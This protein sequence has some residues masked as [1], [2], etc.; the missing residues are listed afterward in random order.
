MPLFQ[1]IIVTD[2]FNNLTTNSGPVD[3]NTEIMVRQ[4]DGLMLSIGTYAEAKARS[5]PG[6]NRVTRRNG[7]LLGFFGTPQIDNWLISYIPNPSY[8]PPAGPYE[9]P[10]GGKFRSKRSRST[11]RSRSKKSRSKKS[12]RSRRH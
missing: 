1:S 6:S 11:K 2:G 10:H 3:P 9:G 4:P 12:K 8:P 7:A 5:P